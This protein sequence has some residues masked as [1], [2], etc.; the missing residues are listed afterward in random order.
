MLFAVCG[1]LAAVFAVTPGAGS[2]GLMLVAACDLLVALIAFVLPWHRWPQRSTLVLGIP[3]FA[4][5][6][7][8]NAQGLLPPRTL[9]V[10]FVL[11]FVWVGSHHRRWQSLWL[12][13]LAAAAFT[14]SVELNTRGIPL[15]P[16]A[17]VLTTVV[18]VLVAETVARSHERLRSA[19]AEMRLLVD[20][21]RDLVTRIGPDGVIRYVSPSV[22]QILG[23]R[24]EEL[25]GRRGADYAHPD[26]PL[27]TERAKANAGQPV[28][29]VRRVRRA[30]GGFTWLET[31]AQ[32]VT[33]PD[34]RREVLQSARDITARREVELELVQAASRDALTGLANRTTFA[35]RLATA[36]A[37]KREGTLALAFVDL[38][39]FKAVND[40][41]GH[42]VGDRLLTRVARRL[43]AMTREQDLVVRYGG[44]EFVVILEGLP[45]VPAVLALI[46]RI[47]VELARP[48]R[49]GSVTAQIA[50]SVGVA[51]A[52]PG[53]TVD[54][55]IAE[56]DSSM[57]ATKA[58]RRVHVPEPRRA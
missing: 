15:D 14:V 38:D 30:D 49:I 32:E 36:L 58:A 4:I 18:S 40:L 55:L 47:D 3:A 35:A 46:N 21:T 33:G 53:T 28:I 9:S 20:H 27:P 8:S 11:V 50:A 19:A 22:E 17:V 48:F 41:H 5:I 16:R 43:E 2:G 10:M 56:A 52:E 12:A 57:Y 23:W 37:E 45:D 51:V 1:L 13:P 29:V 44:D 39:G 25:I 7:A 6:G 54:D 42:L 34:G 24:P 31:V 26:D